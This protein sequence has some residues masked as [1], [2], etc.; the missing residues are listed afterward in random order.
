M[1]SPAAGTMGGMT[2]VGV[3]V[4]DATAE[5]WDDVAVVMGTRGDPSRCWCQFFRLTNTQWNAARTAERRAALHAQV[6]ITRPPGVLAYDSDGQPVGW[7]GLAPRSD[8]PRLATGVVSSATDDEP[9]L[10]AVTCFVVR[11]GARQRGVA[12]ALLDGAIDLA[13]RHGARLV[14]GYPVDTAAKANASSSEL[15][16]GPLSVFLRCGFTEVARPR[17]A[18]PVVRRVLAS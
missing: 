10:W 11:P 5:R 12:S 14:E 2:E 17:G 8:Y 18:R 1:L 13:R 9:G 7:C 4:R 15:F 6:E 3:S 16:H